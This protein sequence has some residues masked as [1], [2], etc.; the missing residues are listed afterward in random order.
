MSPPVRGQ[1]EKI[2]I[3][4]RAHYCLLV[5]YVV[6]RLLNG[7]IICYWSKYLTLCILMDSFFWLDKLG[8]VHC[9]YLGVPDY[10]LNKILHFCLKTLLTLQ[11]SVDPLCGISSGSYPL[12]KA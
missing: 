5:G 9:M 11:N 1:L 2:F 10:N 8:M 7:D 3:M 12:T 4:G 6:A